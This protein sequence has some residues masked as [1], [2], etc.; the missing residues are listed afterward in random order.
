MPL[1]S[2]SLERRKRGPSQGFTHGL[3]SELQAPRVDG[4]I[5]Y[6]ICN[7]CPQ[8]FT[9]VSKQTWYLTTVLVGYVLCITILTAQ[10]AKEVIIL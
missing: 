2:G 3:T 6:L 5:T 7:N 4:G 1:I 10:L 8:R 9:S